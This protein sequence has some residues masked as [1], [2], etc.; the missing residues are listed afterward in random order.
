M[1]RPLAMLRKMTH[2]LDT[3]G[4]AGIPGGYKDSLRS[5]DLPQTA[6]KESNDLIA[7]LWVAKACAGA[8]QQEILQ[9]VI[10]ELRARL[11]AHTDAE[12]STAKGAA[13]RCITSEL[14]GIASLQGC[15]VPRPRAPLPMPPANVN[16]PLEHA[17][18][19]VRRDEAIRVAL[20]ANP[21]GQPQA[22]LHAGRSC[23]FE[24][25]RFLASEIDGTRT[26]P[27]A[28]VV[29]ATQMRPSR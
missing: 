10:F 25:F 19:R 26:G 11:F 13:G 2:W 9:K 27:L 5:Y 6:W 12:A 24:Y 23:L 15:G 22:L 29:G 28:H 20:G 7:M 18:E 14:D 1:R 16:E 21:G 4:F 3:D 8:T 17:A